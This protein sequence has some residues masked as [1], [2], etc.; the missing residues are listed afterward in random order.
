[1]SVNTKRHSILVQ[2]G[3]LFDDAHELRANTQRKVPMDAQGRNRNVSLIEKSQGS[4]TTWVEV[5]VGHG[6]RGFS[7]RLSKS[8]WMYSIV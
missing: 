1:M 8:L 7:S 2:I 6:G 5:S 4:K 3:N